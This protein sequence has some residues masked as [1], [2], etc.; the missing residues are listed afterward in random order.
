MANTKNKSTEEWFDD[1]KKSEIFIHSNDGQCL[2]KRFQKSNMIEVCTNRGNALRGIGVTKKE[3]IWLYPEEAL[4]LSERRQLQVE[5]DDGVSLPVVELYPWLGQAGV[6]WEVYKVYVSLK[7]KG[8]VVRRHEPDGLNLHPSRFE[9]SPSPIFNVYKSSKKFSITNP[10][11]PDIYV[12]IQRGEAI[13]P[14]TCCLK[15]THFL[16]TSAACH[17]FTVDCTGDVFEYNVTFGKPSL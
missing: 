8:F 4:Y 1:L 5:D 15:Q 16:S 14:D 3:Q 12:Y 2:A 11:D 10:G 6:A 17:L 7:L 13:L 9:T